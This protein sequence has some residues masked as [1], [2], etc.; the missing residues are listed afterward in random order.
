MGAAY[1]QRHRFTKIHLLYHLISHTSQTGYTSTGQPV[2]NT[3]YRT[4]SYLRLQSGPVG[5]TNSSQVFVVLL[6]CSLRV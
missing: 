6:T 3:P 4:D 5:S 2:L 1:S